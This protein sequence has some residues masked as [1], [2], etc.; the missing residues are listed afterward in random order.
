MSKITEKV[1]SSMSR[2]ELEKYRHTPG[3][4]L[5]VK[6][7]RAKEME[8][9]AGLKDYLQKLS[10][11]KSA[12]INETDSAGM[13]SLHCAVAFSS[14]PSVILLLKYGAKVNVK[15][16]LGF[17]PL[18]LATG[19]Y[20][21]KE[22]ATHLIQEGKADVNSRNKT[23]GTALHGAAL[24]GNKECLELLLKHGADPRREDE[25]GTTP[26]ELTSDETI[27]GI[28]H[29]AIA[30]SDRQKEESGALCLQCGKHGENM[31]RC[32]QCQQA[33]YCDRNCQI[34]HW[35]TQHKQQCEGF[36]LA[37]PHVMN[38]DTDDVQMSF[39][40]VH[41]SSNRNVKMFSRKP[42]EANQRMAFLKRKRFI[43]KVQTPLGTAHRDMMVYNVD[44]SC[45]GFIHGTEKGYPKLQS[46]IKK[47]GMMGIKAFFWAEICDDQSGEFKVFHGKTA[48]FQNW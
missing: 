43:V 37:R 23:G 31:K 42:Y 40:H 39:Y 47:E 5:A 8:E 16:D 45:E 6:I 12:K 10:D 17:T 46:R 13:T 14:L 38:C 36:V 41:G 35:H 18:F 3:T 2:S 21:D 27:L 34:K 4:D 29:E 44:R 7:G 28:L 9:Y 30:E 20:A 11:E 15:D 1:V 22:I 26:F 48:P 19:R 33:L 32:S 25:D 24:M